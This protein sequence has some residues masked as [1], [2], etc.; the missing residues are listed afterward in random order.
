LEGPQLRAAMK[1]KGYDGLQG[2]RG[3]I[4]ALGNGLGKIHSESYKGRYLGQ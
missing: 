4:T 2:A 1:G 3:S